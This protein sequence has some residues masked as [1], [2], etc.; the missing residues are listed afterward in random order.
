MA[1]NQSQSAFSGLAMEGKPLDAL[2]NKSF[3]V[4]DDK[5]AKQV[6]AAVATLAQVALQNANVISGD[7]VKSIEEM[8]AAID[9]KLSE[10]INEIIHH[11][12][13]QA[14]E[15]S[16]R[17]LAHLVNNSETDEMLQIKVIS[18]SKKEVQKMMKDYKGTKFDQS[19]L[20]KKI[21]EETYGTPGGVPFGAM[22]G[23]YQWDHNAPDVEALQGIA[24]I[25]ASAFTPF[26]SAAGSNLMGMDSWQELPEKRD[27][28]KI[29][30]TPDYAP[31]RSFRES[32]D[33]RYIGLTM[34]RFLSRLPYS[35]KSNPVEEFNFEETIEG[36]DESKYTWSNAAYAMGTNI[37]QAFK[38]YGWCSQIRGTES[39]GLVPNLPCHTFPS[40]DGG[41]DMKC[42]TEVA[43]SDRREQ[44][45]ANLG[46]M[47]LCH[48]KD[49]DFA[50]FFSA[51]SLQRP[52]KYD[53]K[54]AEAN[55]NLSARLPYMFATCRF[56]H[57][58]KVMV[59]DKIGSL[60]ERSDMENWLNNWITQY[61]C[62]DPNAGEETKA[63]LPLAA[64]K[65]EV[66][67]V[68]GNPGYYASRFY[69][70]PHYQLEGLSVSLRLVSQVPS[71]K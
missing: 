25:S 15:G 52:G 9:K 55:A 67:E 26:I 28:A 18:M 37:T 43:V 57:Y 71:G 20:F 17:G 29:F 24:Q 3:K 6:E 59:R 64:A 51:Q 56:A 61:V 39:G 27:L 34:P 2:F 23:D 12:E 46:L 16:W 11:A 5:G 62:T 70:R 47:P 65:V 54:E 8:I 50:V 58:L 32:D 66:V 33:A 44:E 4:K 30:S 19:P 60:K 49:T 1:D 38:F 41:V 13:F 45:L 14:L 35:T 10:Q 36:H 40:S 21:Y 48:Y 42:P 7:A 53:S 22:I 69:L 68:P 63:R 31:W